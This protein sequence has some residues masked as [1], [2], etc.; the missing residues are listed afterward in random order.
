[1]YKGTFPSHILWKIEL[2]NITNAYDVFSKKTAKRIRAAL[3]IMEESNFHLEVEE[4]DEKY[5]EVFEPL[6]V[7]HL[8]KK[9]NPKIADLKERILEHQEHNFPYK[10]VSLYRGDEFLGGLIFSFRSESL[11]AAFKVFPT[12]I[13]LHIPI[14]V[15]FLAEYYFYNYALE[16]KKEAVFHGRD[17]NAFGLNAAIGLALYKLQAGNK[18]YV[19]RA[20]HIEFLEE[21]EWNETDDVLLFLGKERGVPAEK[22]VLFLAGSDELLDNKYA[23]LTKQKY[24][25][26]EIIRKS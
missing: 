21:F 22:A 23:I 19:S 8:G 1:M 26:L 11:N 20:S 18:P 4:V 13:S 25:E 24:F 3:R 9:K 2:E 7:S 16:F 10:G 14:N 17:R 12:S 6:Y 15:S 5:I